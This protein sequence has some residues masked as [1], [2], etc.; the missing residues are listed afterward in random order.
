[1]AD[2]GCA[3]IV[4]ANTRPLMPAPGGAERVVGNNPL[5]I[6]VPADDG[7]IA[8]DLALSA[9]AMGKIRLA[10]SRGEPIPEGWAT[11]SEGVPT[12]DAKEAIAGMLLPAAGPKGFGLALMIDLL[13]GGLSSGALGDAVRPLYG[14]MAKPYCSS[15]LFMAIHIDGF[16]P[17]AEFKAAAAA[18]AKKIRASR[19]APGGPARGVRMPGDR[20]AAA[21]RDFDGHCRIA[22]STLEALRQA[23]AR[24]SVPAP[25]ELLS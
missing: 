13:A 19:P 3:A 8:V 18:F 16:R 20:A 25:E 11:N 4:I 24:L 21:H 23:A 14:D 22:S 7:A 15:H 17:L 5:A 10:D 2:D 6:A 1:M 9:A 12:T